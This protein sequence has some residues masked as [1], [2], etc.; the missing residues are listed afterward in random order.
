MVGVLVG[1]VGHSKLK[2]LIIKFLIDYAFEL[3]FKSQLMYCLDSVFDLRKFPIGY[4]PS[5]DL[6]IS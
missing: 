6:I 5:I 4:F 1:L 2:D 3:L